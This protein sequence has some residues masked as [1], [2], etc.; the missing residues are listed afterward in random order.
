MQKVNRA[1]TVRTLVRLLPHVCSRFRCSAPTS[2]DIE[3]TNRCNLRCRMCW[4]HGENGVGDNYRYGELST[5]EVMC[6]IDRL[7]KHKPNIYLGGAEP[8]MR[9]DLWII[10]DYIKRKG[11][12]VSLTTNGTLLDPV[13]AEMLVRF[14]VDRVN[15]S[16]DGPEDLHDGIRG[17][18]SF[19]KVVSAINELSDHKKKRGVVTP[20]LAVNVTVTATSASH[21]RAALQSVRDATHN[22]PDVYIIHHLWYLTHEELSVHQFSVRQVLGCM[23][24]GAAAHV[25]PSSQVLDPAALA[26]EIVSLKDWPKVTSFPDL[27]YHD[28]VKYYSEGDGIQ[29]RCTAPFSRVVIK[30]NGD[31]KFCPDEWIDDFVLGNIRNESFDSIWNND[32]ARMFRASLFKEKYFAGCKRCSWRYWS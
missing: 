15:F 8:F 6:L 25:I 12:T 14:K 13:K 31:V 23:A 19:K 3:L 27:S 22:G 29:E 5:S 1:H 28:I 2:V 21:L 18:G 4:F 30:P 26:H 10:L 20:T 16:V 24:P 11:L 9:Q 32:K 7:L 17:E